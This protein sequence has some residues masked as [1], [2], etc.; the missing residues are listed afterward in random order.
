MR[1]KDAGTSVTLHDFGARETHP[2]E[3]LPSDTFCGSAAAPP[4]RGSAAAVARFDVPRTAAA[5]RN[6]FM[7]LRREKLANVCPFSS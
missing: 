3:R 4:M 6:A 5:P 1:V 2:R 7:N